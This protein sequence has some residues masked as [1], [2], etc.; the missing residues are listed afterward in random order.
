MTLDL[1]VAILLVPVANEGA[2]LP[3]LELQLDVRRMHGL[4]DLHVQH[5]GHLV[6]RLV[7]GVLRLQLDL[8]LRELTPLILEEEHHS[9]AWFV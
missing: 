2:L 4:H 7:E 8:A 3:A 6:A 9:I 5:A 1:P